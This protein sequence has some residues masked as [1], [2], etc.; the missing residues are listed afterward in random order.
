MPEEWVP[1]PAP[2]KKEEWTPHNEEPSIAGTAVGVSRGFAEGLVSLPGQ[3]LKIGLAQQRVSER[4][5]QKFVPA[6][7]PAQTAAEYIDQ[8]QGKIDEKIQSFGPPGYSTKVGPVEISGEAVGQLLSGAAIPGAVFGKAGQGAKFA[9]RLWSSMKAGAA[10]GAAGSL[11]DVALANTLQEAQDRLVN[12]GVNI[13]VGGLLAGA[14]HGS[15]EAVTK[16]LSLRTMKPVP[17]GPDPRVKGGEGVPPVQVEDRWNEMGEYIY[18]RMKGS[19]TSRQP[20]E[21]HLDIKPGLEDAPKI[22]L[23]EEARIKAERIR[24]PAERVSA[25]VAEAKAGREKRTTEDIDFI[26]KGEEY[27]ELKK[28]IDDRAPVMK[29]QKEAADRIGR[30]AIDK[31]ERDK[32]AA[33]IKEQRTDQRKLNAL[34]AELEAL[35]EVIAARGRPAG[36]IWEPSTKPDSPVTEAYQGELQ[37]ELNARVQ[38]KLYALEG[39]DP[40]GVQN[41]TK[42]QTIPD[43]LTEFTNN[44]KEAT[45]LQKLPVDPKI[46]ETAHQVLADRASFIKRALD[47]PVRLL[48]QTVDGYRKSFDPMHELPAREQVPLDLLAQSEQLELYHLPALEQALREHFSLPER[49]LPALMNDPKGREILSGVTISPDMSMLMDSIRVGYDQ[50]HNLGVRKGVI[51]ARAFYEDYV[52]RIYDRKTAKLV[53]DFLESKQAFQGDNPHSMQRVFANLWDAASAGYKPKSLDIASLFPDYVRSL[54]R[55][56]VHNEVLDALKVA[57]PEAFKYLAEKEHVPGYKRAPEGLLGNVVIENGVPKQLHIADREWR[58]I[59]NMISLS[60]PGNPV[61]RW[62]AW[63]KKIVLSL[64]IYHMWQLQRA[65]YSMTGDIPFGKW[66]QGMAMLSPA[67]GKNPLILEGV[68]DGQLSIMGAET[69]RVEFDKFVEKL[70][71]ND[72]GMA[73]LVKLAGKPINAFSRHLWSEVSPGLTT[74][75][76][77]K[78]LERLLHDPTMEGKSR[79]EL[80]QAAAK[81]ANEAMGQKNWRRYGRNRAVEEMTRLLVLAPQWLETRFRLFGGG[82][83]ALSEIEAANMNPYSK[84]MTLKPTSPEGNLYARYWMGYVAQGIGTAVLANAVIQANWPEVRKHKEARGPF[85]L[86]GPF[87]LPLT[88]IVFPHEDRNGRPLVMSPFPGLDYILEAAHDWR[89]FYENRTSPA[90]KGLLHLITGRDYKGARDAPASWSFDTFLHVVGDLIPLPMFYASGERV[91]GS[92]TPLHEGEKMLFRS[93][94][95]GLHNHPTFPTE[96]LNEEEFLKNRAAQLKKSAD[97]ARNPIYKT[98]LGWQISRHNAAVDRWVQAVSETEGAERIAST[99]QKNQRQLYVGKP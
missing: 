2:A 30:D 38:Q 61:S 76:Y 11:P 56:I 98:V 59:N 24:T 33:L 60:K 64:D 55:T 88:R 50:L 72:P 91:V 87:D 40:E 77:V 51:S 62:N 16:L 48:M 66:Q 96:L 1:G 17:I 74:L 53:M 21:P 57:A 99:I 23:E 32:A 63:N 71:Q 39:S 54:N 67:H 10:F 18:D 43:I 81:I 35:T 37:N 83:K 85:G 9:G 29:A 46:S 94:V 73:R 13:T 93:L 8:I 31:V 25:Q 89:R 78:N 42:V 15:T 27:V 75:A 90:M 4:L 84:G 6:W 45:K 7:H 22:S 47:G 95:L 20:V 19:G 80:V 58:V 97:G 92:E 70:A 5:I 68:R 44:V 69:T 12:A 41:A 79:K 34:N 28:R 3:F 65:Y 86:P 49:Q 36:T 82:L 14:M 52:N 26:T